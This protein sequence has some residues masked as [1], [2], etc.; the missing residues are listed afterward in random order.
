MVI[1]KVGDRV[2]D[3]LLFI[4]MKN[5]LILFLFLAR[6]PKQQQLVDANTDMKLI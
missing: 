4:I 2:A 1:T 6:P 5:I 3:K